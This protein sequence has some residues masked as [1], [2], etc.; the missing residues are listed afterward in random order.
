MTSSKVFG[1][2]RSSRRLSSRLPKFVL[3]TLDHCSRAVFFWQAALYVGHCVDVIT[4]GFSRPLRTTPIIGGLEALPAHR[5]L[6][7]N[8]DVEQLKQLAADLGFQLAALKFNRAWFRGHG[9]R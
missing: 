5:G 4:F 8:V 2:I 3:S 9:A 6:P 7:G 1:W